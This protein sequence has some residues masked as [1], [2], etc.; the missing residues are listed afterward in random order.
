MLRR[1]GVAYLYFRQLKIDI[2]YIIIVWLKQQS[3]FKEM[4]YVIDND[5]VI[6]IQRDNGVS[7]LINSS[8]QLLDQTWICDDE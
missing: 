2:K 6:R 7:L 1:I 3:I 4:R 8:S 5:S